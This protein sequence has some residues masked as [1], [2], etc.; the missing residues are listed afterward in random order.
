MGAADDL[1]P[2]APS[3]VA[4]PKHAAL[5]RTGCEFRPGSCSRSRHLSSTDAPAARV[6]VRHTMN[7]GAHPAHIFVAAELIVAA[8]F[9]LGA[10]AWGL[11]EDDKARRWWKK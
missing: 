6:R 3:P 9:M 5:G 2:A 11:R 4:G 7:P 10:V 8:I 1:V